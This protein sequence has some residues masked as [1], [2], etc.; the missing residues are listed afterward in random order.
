M[1]TTA[2]P[3]HYAAIALDEKLGSIG[4]QKERK[5]ERTTIALTTLT[6]TLCDLE[7][8]ALLLVQLS[9]LVCHL[10]SS[11]LVARSFHL[12]SIISSVPC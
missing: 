5:K 9:L 2:P 10:L 8:A 12:A 3:H 6:Q 4:A 11:L 1:Y 7:D